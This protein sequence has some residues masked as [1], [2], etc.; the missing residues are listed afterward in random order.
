MAIMKGDRF[1]DKLTGKLY[2]VKVI[3]NG[4]L[5]LEGGDTPNR[6]WIGDGD[7]NLFFEMLEKR[8]KRQKLAGIV[9][10]EN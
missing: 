1:K 3:K 7:V 5:V 2:E 8:G 9:I 6:I 10:N 4:T